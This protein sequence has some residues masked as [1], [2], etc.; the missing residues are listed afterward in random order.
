MP[1]SEMISIIICS[2]TPVLSLELS[3]NIDKTI[4]TEYQIVTIDN[5]RNQ[6]N[7]FTAYQEGVRRAIGEYLCF[8]HD[9]VIFRTDGWGEKIVEH[10]KEDRVGAI[11]VA[12]T[13]FLPAIPSGWW[14]PEVVSENI[15]HS[16]NVSGEGVMELSVKDEYKGITDE[17]VAADGVFLC[18]RRSLFDKISWDV[19]TFSGFHGY[20]LDICLQVLS[21]GY[22]V[23]MAWDILLEHHSFGNYSMSFLQAIQK[24][25]DKWKDYLPIVKGI[26]MSETEIKLRT[27]I[28]DLK[29]GYFK[30]NQFR[31][32][33]EYK[34]GNAVLHPFS[35]IER[36]IKK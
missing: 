32:S 29:H 11:G 23:K 27:R 14:E 33:K 5:S 13:H 36:R 7:I 24:V 31:Y 17:L 28:V 25:Y 15:L 8:V 34:V 10:F 30:E 12:G 3:E 18:I 6:Y 2:R 9:D 35:V 26:T 16:M 4:G 22:S 19:Q 21:A 20:D 1:Y